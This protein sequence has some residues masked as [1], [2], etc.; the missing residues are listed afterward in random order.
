LQINLYLL[1]EAQN[2]KS[3]G[4][5][6]SFL[7][8]YA[9]LTKFFNMPNVA[10]DTLVHYVKKYCAKITVLNTNKKDAFGIYEVKKLWYGLLEIDGE[11]ENWSKLKLRTFMLAIFQHKTCCRFS[12]TQNILIENIKYNKDYFKI[13]VQKSKTDQSAKGEF[14]YL[15]K[16]CNA[17]MDAHLLFLQIHSSH[18]I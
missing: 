18:G 3:I 6:E 8:T 7:G 9:L 4:T 2:K 14:V 16:V 17:K 1:T 15:T 13:L 12:D 5:L 10:N 11:F